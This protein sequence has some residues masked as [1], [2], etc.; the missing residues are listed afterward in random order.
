ML[1]EAIKGQ[2][3]QDSLQGERKLEIKL[4]GQ[5]GIICQVILSW[6][7]HMSSSKLLETV[8]DKMKS[9][10]VFSVKCNFKLTNCCIFAKIALPTNYSHQFVELYYVESIKF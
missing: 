10:T 1:K 3:T 8:D 7:R 4:S 2:R 9:N 5:R 6:E